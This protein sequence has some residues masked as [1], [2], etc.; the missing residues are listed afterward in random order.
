MTDLL[1]AMF[2]E[3]TKP[4]TVLMQNLMTIMSNTADS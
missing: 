2:I 1:S 4:D 3:A